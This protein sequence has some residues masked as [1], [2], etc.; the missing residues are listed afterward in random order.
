MIPLNRCI[1]LLSYSERL[2]KEQRESLIFYLKKLKSLGTYS[3]NTSKIPIKS[4]FG[5]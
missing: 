4:K 1:D 5:G 3:D 2:T